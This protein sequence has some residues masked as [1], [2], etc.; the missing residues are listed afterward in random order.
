MRVRCIERQQIKHK[1]FWEKIPDRSS[2]YYDK[3]FRISRIKKPNKV[4]IVVLAMYSFYLTSCDIESV[5]YRVSNKSSPCL[6]IFDFSFTHD[7]CPA[8]S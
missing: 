2:C 8:F 7:S 4:F 5:Y 3:N 6:L 1:I